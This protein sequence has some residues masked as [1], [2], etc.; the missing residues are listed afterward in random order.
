MHYS[1]CAKILSYS[2]GLPPVGACPYFLRHS[3]SPQWCPFASCR[4]L[5]PQ[6]WTMMYLHWKWHPSFPPDPIQGSKEID[7]DREVGRNV[8]NGWVLNSP[9]DGDSPVSLL[10]QQRP[11]GRAGNA[12]FNNRESQ[13]GRVEG[14]HWEAELSAKYRCS[15]SAL[16]I[17]KALSSSYQ[18]R[19]QS[20]WAL[21]CLREPL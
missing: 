8:Q 6:P 10:T 5:L 11:A 16:K 2:K 18:S 19:I 4:S 17:C 3:H 13:M 15:W 21:S 1:W 14:Q 9:A 12:T 20:T 7:F